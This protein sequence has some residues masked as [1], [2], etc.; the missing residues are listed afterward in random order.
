MDYAKLGL[1]IGLEIHQQLDSGHKLFCNCPLQKSEEFPLETR[2]RLRVV[3][4]ETG[5]YDPAA[6]YEFIRGRLFV[7]RSNADSSCLTELDDDPPHAVNPAALTTTLQMCKLL[8]CAVFDE[9]H[10]M[11]KTV[12]DGSSVSGFQRTVLV[13][14]GGSVETSAG[15]IGI[16]TVC[17]EEDS[18]PAM[19]REGGTVEYRLD[20][21]G[22]PLIEIATSASMHTPQHAR[23]AAETIGMLLRSLNVMRGIGTIRQD[24]NISIEGGSRV[25]IKGFQELEKMEKVIESEVQRQLS[26]LQIKN[27]LHKRGLKTINI[28]PVDVT[29]IFKNTKNNFIRSA[30]AG[31]GTVLALVLPK[32]AGLLKLQCGDRTFGKELNG[33]AQA[34][35]YGFIHSDEYLDRYE[36]NAE[37][38]Q[39]RKELKAGER[40]LVLVIAGKS[41]ERAADAVLRRSRQCLVG[42]PEETRIADGIGSKYTRPLPGAERMYPET[43]IPPVRITPEVLAAVEVP[44]TL[45]EKEAALS[46]ELPKELA[47]QLVKSRQ[48]ALYER[49]REKTGAEPVLIASTLLSTC[50]DLRRQGH[51]VDVIA[52]ES[53]EQLFSL[54]ARKRLSKASLPDALVLLSQ[55]KTVSEVL[56]SFEMLSDAQ[57]TAIV[58]DVL[59]QHKGKKESVLM[60][61]VM[62]KAQGRADGRQVARILR[63]L[64]E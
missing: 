58:A 3:A 52:P 23:E 57:V 20:R 27:E 28:K 53:L 11:R 29:S 32:C 41:P 15:T 19:R 60:G 18:A 54:V 30:V 46:K 14:A 35:G 39:L 8:G 22:I 31:S 17:L 42:V 59:R 48:F 56:S 37:F 64:A 47:A 44:E 55:G 26:L 25:E 45:I 12:I 6:L 51:A 10:V 34:Y 7:Y 49:I 63:E 43:D 24:V 50:T 40:D 5:A 1:R 33:Y 4:G 21:L 36:L 38:G 13:G 2:R 16:Q 61:L 9:F 62:E